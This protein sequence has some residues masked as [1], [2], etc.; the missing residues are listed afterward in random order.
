MAWCSV[1]GST[2]MILKNLMGRDHADDI[3]VDGRVTLE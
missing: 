2:G 1:R 3:E